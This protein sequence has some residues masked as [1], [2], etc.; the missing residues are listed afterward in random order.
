M[1]LI[2]ANLLLYAYDDTAPLHEPAKRWLLGRFDGEETIGI[3]VASALA[4][5]RIATNP[6]IFQ[7]PFSIGEACDIVGEW[8]TLPNVVLLA[9]TDRHWGIFA[10][11][12]K[13][14]QSRGPLVPDADLA[15][16][17]LEHGAVLCTHDRDFSRFEKVK[18]EFPLTNV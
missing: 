7:R 17:A 4:F 18:V 6:R 14:S 3:A 2:D 10:D 12:A 1:K 15:A 5:V 8:L 9:P 13:T 16:T 11:V